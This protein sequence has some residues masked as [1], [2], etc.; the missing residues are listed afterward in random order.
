LSI[1]ESGG[2]KNIRQDKRLD[3][4]R[5]AHNEKKENEIRTDRMEDYLEVI[6]ELIQQKG[7]ANTADISKYLN[8]SSPSVTKMVKK[9]DEN[10]YLIYEKYRG[11]RLT[12]EGIQ[13]AKNIQE[14]HSLFVEFLKMIGIDDDTAHI[15]AEGIEHHLHPQ[16]I[17]KLEK[18]IMIL[19]KRDP[20]L[21]RDLQQ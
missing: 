15:D 8:V 10:R 11:L 1:D 21:I 5:S 2:I 19:K 3:F 18:F 13:I 17:K 7:Y 6:Y 14:K 9:L 12:S 4:I 16:T 20:K